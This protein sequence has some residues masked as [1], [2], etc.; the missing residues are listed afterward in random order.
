MQYFGGKL[1]AA[2]L[3]MVGWMGSVRRSLQGALEV[4]WGTEEE[5]QEEEEEDEEVVDV[6]GRFQRAMTPLHSFARRSRKSLHRFS[7]RSRQTLQRR[8]PESRSVSAEIRHTHLI[9]NKSH[10]QQT[11]LYTESL[12]VVLMCI[13]S[14]GKAL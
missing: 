14:L 12:T 11:Q 8:T 4:V 3:H 7:L 1:S 9:H 2:Q 6:G 13:V 10:E 5:K